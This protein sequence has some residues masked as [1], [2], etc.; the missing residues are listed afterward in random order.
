M[1]KTS[2]KKLAALFGFLTLC[3]ASLPALSAEG[4]VTVAILPFTMNADK[5]LS[6]LRNGIVDMLTSRI[7]WE[8]K[9]EVVEK[10]RVKQLMG[11]YTG[12][13]NMEKAS[14]FGR[15]LA[16]DYVLFGSVT[17]FGESVSLDATMAALTKDEPPVTVFT[18]IQGMESVIPEVNRF[19]QKVNAG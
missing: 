6:H 17:I 8:G 16:A 5:N 13:L 7:A 12:P 19:A 2:K 18:Q 14:G 9:V 10:G 3:F 1:R 15:E 11:D 4:P